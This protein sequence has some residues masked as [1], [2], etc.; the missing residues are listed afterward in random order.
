[1]GS[2]FVISRLSIV[3]MESVLAT[4]VRTREIDQAGVDIGRRGLRQTRKLTVADFPSGYRTQYGNCGRGVVDDLVRFKLQEAST[5]G[6][7]QS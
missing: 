4:K 5:R 7:R 6:H 2:Q 3:E 1:M